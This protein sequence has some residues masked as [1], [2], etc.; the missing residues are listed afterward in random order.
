MPVRREA[1][2]PRVVFAGRWRLTRR[3]TSG[4]WQ[5]GRLMVRPGRGAARV[6]DAVLRGAMQ[7]GAPDGR[8]RRTGAVPLILPRRDVRENPRFRPLQFAAQKGMAAAVRMVFR[9]VADM[10]EHRFHEL[11]H[12]PHDRQRGHEAGMGVRLG[13]ATGH[14]VWP[15]DMGVDYRMSHKKCP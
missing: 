8:R 7:S 10:G 2:P 5:G 1:L 15:P 14:D 12:Q 6:L 13:W 3:P 11:H 4:A 9:Q